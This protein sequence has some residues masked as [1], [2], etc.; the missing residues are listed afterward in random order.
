MSDFIKVSAPG[1]IC[2]FGEHQDYL[3]LPVITAAINLRIEIS[4]RS[5]KERIIELDLP[6]IGD[7]EKFRV[8]SEAEYNRKRDYF[9][10]VFNQFYRGGFRLNFGLK[11]T[12]HGQ[13]P[14]NSGTS[15][16]S[17]LCVAWS[18]AMMELVN[19][20][21]KEDPILVARMAH[22]AEVLEFQEPGGMMDHIT[23]AV[24]G[25]EYIDFEPKLSVKRLQDMGGHFILGDSQEPKDT[26]GILT[27]V[28]STTLNSVRKIKKMNPD[29][30]LHSVVMQD[31]EDYQIILTTEEFELLQ[32]AILNRNITYAARDLFLMGK[33]TPSKLGEM[34]NA[35]QKILRNHLRISTPKIDTMLEAAIEAGGVGGKIN[36]S[37][38]GG[39]MFVYVDKDPQPVAEAIRKV[40][41]IPYIIHVDEGVRLETDTGE[42]MENDPFQKSVLEK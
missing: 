15:S 14:I 33:M 19:F 35:L 42:N 26:M 21:Q 7:R 10:S 24:G 29:F 27:R 6:D 40:G 28:K 1:R 20:P 41:G 3:G 37:G 36:G 9:K 5:Q 16:S 25:I 32:A 30:D 34:L 23:S 4:L 18:R 39:C 2:L 22:R 12:V 38:G 11:G 31:I 13:I 8:D 17:A